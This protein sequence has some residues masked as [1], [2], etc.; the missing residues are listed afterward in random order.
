MSRGLIGHTGFVGSNLDRQSI[1]DRRFNSQ[2][3]HDMAGE[4][5][6]LLVCAGVSAVKWA[7]N[8]Q[9]DDDRRRIA[10]LTDVLS[11]VTADEFVLISTIDVYPDPAAGGDEDTVI[12]PYANHAYGRHRYELEQWA[13][14]NF[15]KCGVVRLP[16]L[17]GPG[18][19]K[20]ALFDRIHGNQLHAI[21]P[22]GIFQW[23]P[24]QRL[25]QDIEI[26]RRADLGLINLFTEPLAMGEIITRYFPNTPV[27]PASTPAP[28]YRVAT[29]H[30][31]LFGR[32]DGFIQSAAKC[33]AHIGDFIASETTMR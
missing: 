10:D 31:R 27:D 25:W 33:L 6:D 12:D 18:M 1:F 21:N 19:K 32:S 3:F 9:P 15:R 5:F 4:H 14:A 7:A 20:N 13:V 23:Y 8:Q 22:A 28:I 29:R 24:V 11:K 16:A 2:N 26:A 17:F 30:A